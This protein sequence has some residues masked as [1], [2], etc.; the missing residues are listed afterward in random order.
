M[1]TILYD[2]YK[3]SY[4]NAI[5]D[6]ILHNILLASSF[7][8]LYTLQS[9]CL[10]VFPTIFLSLMLNRTFII[11]H[12]CV[13]N[14]YSPNHT[15]NNIVATIYGILTFTSTNWILDHKTH[16]LTNGNITN[17]Y[18]FKFNEL[19]YYNL[20][21]Y[22]Q[23][24]KFGKM[25]AQFFYHPL[26]FFT[27]FPFLYFVILQRFMYLMKKLKYGDKIN[28]TLY[29]IT[30]N[31]IFNNIG[32]G[33]LLYSIN[34]IGIMPYYL[35]AVYFSFILDFLLFF[36][37]HTFNPPYV[38]TNE[39]WNFN[40]SGI[41]GSSF[42]IIPWYLKYFTCGI[43]YHHIHHIISLIPGYNMKKYHDEVIQSSNTFDNIIKLSLYDCYN[44]LWLMLY[45]TE[46]KRYITL[47]EADNK[48]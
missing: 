36:C 24:T 13:H 31:H 37:Q 42:I 12:D 34:S 39:L 47:K 40:N 35:I 11:F 21:E 1:T 30:A 43:E 20:N 4:Y 15:L 33:I 14:S 23:F 45:D 16:H 22:K 8:S 29:N 9:S 38:V 25:L 48:I 44:N 10:V 32:I 41:M 2:K 17:T 26:V 6:M 27:F 19:V 28:N 46:Q 7:Y 5:T 3:S 18:K